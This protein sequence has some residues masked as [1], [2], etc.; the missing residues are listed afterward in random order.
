[1]RQVYQC[2]DGKCF[3]NFD[4][5]KQHE[6]CLVENS[7]GHLIDAHLEYVTGSCI[8]QK[9]AVLAFIQ[10]QAFTLVPLLQ[11]SLELHAQ[12]QELVE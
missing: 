12:E 6:L 8:S 11:Q 7:L 2:I 10:S 9:L 4:K 5:A 1:M 3:D